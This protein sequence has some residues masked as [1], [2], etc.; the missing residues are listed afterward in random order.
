MT[1]L[2]PILFPRT[3]MKKLIITLYTLAAV[4]VVAQV[5][6]NP[7]SG[8]VTAI[9]FAGDGSG[10]TNIQAANIVG[11]VGGSSL[12]NITE[13]AE[14]IFV[15]GT[16]YGTA[17]NAMVA[18]AGAAQFFIGDN[19]VQDAGTTTV[20]ETAVGIGVGGL[21]IVD[22][23]GLGVDGGVSLATAGGNTTIGGNLIVGGE[24]IQG[25]GTFYQ[26]NTGTATM[27]GEGRNWLVQMETNLFTVLREATFS[28]N[29]TAQLFTGPIAGSLTNDI[30]GN[31][32]TATLASHLATNA[33]VTNIT[34]AGTLTVGTNS[35][36][37]AG[38]W[39]NGVGVTNGVLSLGSA[40]LTN[41]AANTLTVT[42][43]NSVLVAGYLRGTYRVESGVYQN[44]TFGGPVSI[45]NSASATRASIITL[46]GTNTLV[47][48]TQHVV[49]TL[50]A[51]NS[52]I[53]PAANMP[54]VA[55]TL[56]A[57]WNSNGVLFAV[58]AAFTNQIAPS[59]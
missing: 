43:V 44:T 40:G 2:L 31:A 12:S 9:T 29:V 4:A 14:G 53:L 28:S 27:M 59:P 6:V 54:S 33:T 46:H 39:I 50:T 30:S 47:N 42:P 8:D 26:T 49:D 57:L 23:G 20:F 17:T 55:G 37:D 11:A 21:S 56:I 38:S 51:S 32:A 1:R 25:G 35:V 41:S 52:I 36:S 19:M 3:T 58:G 7:T 48:G 18:Q 15:T 45:G 24:I 13:T 5:R 16:I 34:V 22:G 10:I